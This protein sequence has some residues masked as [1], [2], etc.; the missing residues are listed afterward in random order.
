MLGRNTEMSRIERFLE[1]PGP[2]LFL[3]CGGPRTGKTRLLREAVGRPEAVWIRGTALPAPVLAR[4]IARSLVRQIDQPAAGHGVPAA[5]GPGGAAGP[6]QP[7][8]QVLE[9]LSALPHPPPVVLDRADDLLRDRRFV[10]GVEEWTAE[11]RAHGRRAHLVLAVSDPS[12]PEALGLPPGARTGRLLGL[13]A[14]RLDLGPLSLR[15]VGDAAPDWSAEEVVS[16]YGLVGGLPD[17]WSRLD[18]GVRP[19]TNLVRL[20]LGP[21]A[22]LREL[23]RTLLGQPQGVNERTRSLVRALARGARSWGGLRQEAGA[24]RS[25]GELGPYM[26]RLQDSGVASAFRS[27][28]A[29]PRSRDRRYG[30][31]HPFMAFWHGAVRPALQELDGGSTPGRVFNDLISPHLPGLVTRAL[32]GMVQDYLEAH[33]DERFPGVARE[34]GGAWGE[35]YD[36]EVA[37]TLVSGVAVY[38]HLHWSDPAPPDAMDRLLGEIRAARY[39][40][41]REA[42]IPFLLLRH[43]PD[44]DL[45]RRAARVPGAVLLRPGD[46]LGRD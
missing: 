20:V 40:F 41:G 24:F 35:G 23:A 12:L 1:S 34:S 39:G 16:V 15:E 38:G 36:I 11:L 32:P 18:P 33:G 44:H 29:P 2:A 31:L 5:S 19:G 13:D 14:T 45:A 17:F 6:W 30:L 22:P 7:V 28:D 42:R 43:A 46:L 3:I 25:S 21:D 10:R 27:L 37:A 4:D 26:R 9:R 8:F